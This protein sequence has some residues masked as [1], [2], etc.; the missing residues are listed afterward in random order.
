MDIGELIVSDWIAA[1]QEDLSAAL[2]LANIPYLVPA[3]YLCGQSVEKILKA[4]YIAKEN[5]LIKTHDLDELIEKCEKHSPDFDRFMDACSELT[6]Y[7]TIRY[8]PNRKNKKLTVQN[9]NQALKY[10]EDILDFTKAKLK[11][12]GYE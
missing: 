5:R 11:E 4:Y 1:A 10:A 2:N 6:Q 7:A 9:M 8:P 12:L 3:C